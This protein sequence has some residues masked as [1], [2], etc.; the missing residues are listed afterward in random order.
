MFPKKTKGEHLLRTEDIL[1]VIEKEGDTIAVVL[2]PGVQYYTGQYFE[3][4]KITAAAHK[5]GCMVGWDL[6]HAAGNV[7][8]KLHDWN[9]DFAGLFEFLF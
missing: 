9:V 7:V 3:I 8:L 1:E 6:A 4:E 2:L 5:K